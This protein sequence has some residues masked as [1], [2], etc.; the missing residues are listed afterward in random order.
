MHDGGRDEVLFEQMVEQGFDESQVAG[1]H[2]HPVPLRHGFRKPLLAGIQ[3]FRG[4]G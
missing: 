4:M 3:E 1:T 2:P